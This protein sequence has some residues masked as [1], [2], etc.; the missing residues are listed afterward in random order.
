MNTIWFLSKER[1]LIISGFNK[2]IKI[3]PTGQNANE[4]WIKEQDGS[5]RKLAVGEKADMLEQYL[6]DMIWDNFP[7]IISDGENF[8]T[9]LPVQE[10]EVE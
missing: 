2:V 5:S 4:L 3:T 6:L 7:S 1:N 9:N 8:G 10:E